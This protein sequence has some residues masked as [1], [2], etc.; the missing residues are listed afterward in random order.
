MSSK[1]GLF[2][3]ARSARRAHSEGGSQGFYSGRSKVSWLSDIPGAQEGSSGGSQSL[4]RGR[5][6]P[7]KLPRSSGTG[8]RE[9][10]ADGLTSLYLEIKEKL[11]TL[12]LF[13]IFSP[14]LAAGDFSVLAI[15]VVPKGKK[16]YLI[17]LKAPPPGNKFIIHF[18]IFSTA[19]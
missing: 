1:I 5:K 10:H 19:G 14:A 13:S 9:R 18:N 17:G 2:R 12:A 7:P 8:P 15:C 4:P 11:R 3:K 6:A 16:V